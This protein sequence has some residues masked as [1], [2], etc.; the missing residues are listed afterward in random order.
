MYTCHIKYKCIY[1]H[2]CKQQTHL[3]AISSILSPGNA[4]AAPT[5]APSFMKVTVML[6]R[7]PFNHGSEDSPSGGGCVCVCVL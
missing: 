4:S 2:V 1:V 6:L 5:T 3:V 7:M